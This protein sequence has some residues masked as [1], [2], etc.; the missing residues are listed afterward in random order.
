MEDNPLL[1]W[2]LSVTLGQ[3]GFEV[4]APAS[5][6]DLIIALGGERFDVLVT[7]CNLAECR[8]GFQVLALARER[9]PGILAIL[10]SAQTDPDLPGRALAAGFDAFLPKPV[11]AVEIAET[12]VGRRLHGPA[13][14]TL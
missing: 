1:R 4:A 11:R 12:I 14:A 3:Q 8:D 5:A 13:E 9:L 10:I 2:W 7:D 6:D